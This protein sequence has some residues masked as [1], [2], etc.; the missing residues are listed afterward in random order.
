MVWPPRTTGLSGD[1]RTVPPLTGTMRI[2][3]FTTQLRY[4]SWDRSA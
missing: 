4:L 2:A 3:S 1:T